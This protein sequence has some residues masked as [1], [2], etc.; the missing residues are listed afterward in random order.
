MDNRSIP[1]STVIPEVPCSDVPEA[2]AWL[3]GAFGFAERLRV[4]PP[5]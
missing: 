1:R 5:S 2:A 3:C 4:L